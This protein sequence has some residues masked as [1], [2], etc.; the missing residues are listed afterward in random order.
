MGEEASE[1]GAT[2][3]E[4]TEMAANLRQA[5]E[6]GVAGFSATLVRR[7]VGHQGKPLACALADMDELTAYAH[8]LRDLG[9]GTIQVNVM[10]KL[11]TLEDHEA[12]ILELLLRES[13]RTVTY[14]G[15]LYRGDD[16]DAVERMLQKAEPLRV[17][18]AIPQTT[19]RPI[20]IE[21]DFRNP[22]VFAD[23]QAFKEVLNRPVDEQKRIYADAD[24]RARA[25]AE[26]KE[27]GKIF[28]AAWEGSVVHR[29]NSESLITLLHRSVQVIAKE[30]DKPPFDVM[31][32]LALEDN[33]EIKLLGDLVNTN[34]DHLRK[35]ITDPRILIGLADGGAH[36]DMLFEAGFPTYMLGHWVREEQAL[37]I[38]EAVRR[39]TSEPADYFGLHDR[40][41]LEAGKAADLMIFDPD[42]VG[43]AEKATELRNDLPAGG[44]RLYAPKVWNM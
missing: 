21:V 30:R 38:E 3:A 42:R 13:G 28:G 34:P 16:P 29:T 8:V 26:L 18:G 44:A 39:M 19:I 43:S 6:A 36:V 41:R 11:A 9:R 23:V 27:G 40:G 32:D 17:R 15:A 25:V 5:M 12:E 10:E 22:F 33:L 4:R 7:Q 31:I 20:T 2:E 24:W 35:H 1:R 14:S 37:T